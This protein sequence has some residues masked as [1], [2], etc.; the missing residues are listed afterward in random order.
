[1]ADE[2]FKRILEAERKADEK[3]MDAKRKVMEIEREAETKS[4]LAH[5]EIYRKIVEDAKRK[6]DGIVRQATDE[7]TAE[8]KRIIEESEKTLNEI[9]ANVKANLRKA[10][11]SA[12]DM[13]VTEV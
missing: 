1:M 10:I 3:L 4:T 2:T 12:V 9:R 6:A 5:D 8:A 7:A 13:I 11:R